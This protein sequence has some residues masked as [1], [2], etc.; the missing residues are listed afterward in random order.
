MR[1][2]SGRIFA[3]KGFICGRIARLRLEMG[4]KSD[5]GRMFGAER[6]LYALLFLPFMKWPALKGLRWQSCGGQEVGGTS[7]SRDILMIGN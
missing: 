4:A 5:F 7:D 1:S 3:K 6:P 2:V